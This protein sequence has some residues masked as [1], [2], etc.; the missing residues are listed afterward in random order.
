MERG[1]LE[2]KRVDPDAPEASEL[3]EAYFRELRER[4]APAHVEVKGRWADDFRGARAAVVLA[5]EAGRAVGCAGLRPLEEG[6]LE[7]KHFFLAPGVRGRGFGRVLLAGVEEVARSLGA[8]RIVL[9]TAAPLLEAAAL[10]RS[11]GYG[12]ISRFNDNPVAV[13]WFAKNLVDDRSR[14]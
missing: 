7:L 3:L 5:S 6:T 8:R 4:L 12:D 9:D 10:Y 2:V 14:G 1:R 11:S 13:A